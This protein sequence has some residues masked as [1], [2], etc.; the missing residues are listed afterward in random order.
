MKQMSLENIA[1]A[2]SGIYVGP[3]EAKHIE[4]TGVTSDSR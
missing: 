1:A 4:V 2:C 3:E